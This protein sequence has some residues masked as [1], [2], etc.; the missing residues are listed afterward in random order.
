MFK[1]R[2]MVPRSKVPLLQAPAPVSYSSSFTHMY[3]SNQCL[4]Q[5]VSNSLACLFSFF[6]LWR[7]GFNSP[8]KGLHLVLMKWI[9]VGRVGLVAWLVGWQWAGRQAE[10]LHCLDQIVCAFWRTRFWGWALEVT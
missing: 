4:R 8:P 3:A 6:D 10:V 5:H 7:I 2:P 9:Q 1:C